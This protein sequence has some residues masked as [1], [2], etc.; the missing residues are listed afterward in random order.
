MLKF[1]QGINELNKDSVCSILEHA[2]A[3]GKRYKTQY[4]N[5]DAVI[6]RVNSANATQKENHKTRLGK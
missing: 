5:L 4:Y 1:W 3:D 2:A 6:Y